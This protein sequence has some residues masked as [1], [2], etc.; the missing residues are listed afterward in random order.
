[1]NKS[2]IPGMDSM[3]ITSKLKKKG[4][5]LVTEGVACVVYTTIFP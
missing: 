4:V 3:G 2:I 5:F 1:V